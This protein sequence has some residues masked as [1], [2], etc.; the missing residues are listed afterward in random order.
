MPDP[1]APTRR[2]PGQ[3]DLAGGED[4]PPRRPDQ[5]A[6]E[7]GGEDSPPDGTIAE[8]L[9][10]VNDDARRAGLALDAERQRDHPRS[11][12][13]AQVQRLAEP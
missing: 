10:W 7:A 3:A 6:P 11:S 12:L 2:R 1:F 4:S 9:A 5:V 8:V 13:V